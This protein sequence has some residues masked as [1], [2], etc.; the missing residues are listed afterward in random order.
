[1]ID[2]NISIRVERKKE[3]FHYKVNPAENS[4]ANNWHNNSLDTIFILKDGRVIRSYPCQ[5][6][7]NHPDYDTHDTIADGSFQV[8]CFV[9]PRAFHGH[10]H[11]IINTFDVDCE[12]IDHESM[13]S[14]EG[15]FQNGRWL[16]HDR[17]SFK[18]GKDTN[19]AWSGGCFILSSKD[20]EDFNDALVC[21]GV[22]KGQVLDG[23]IRTI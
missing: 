6:V 7:A 10:I 13:Q 5:T 3:S 15:G 23:T 16:I 9:P 14:T 2:N 8:R 11:A 19:F 4:Y 1:M 22:Q 21:L 17:Y 18:T 20:L 12:W